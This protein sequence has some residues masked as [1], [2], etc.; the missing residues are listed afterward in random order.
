MFEIT[1]KIKIG[2]NTY[3][4]DRS[5]R[6][7]DLHTD[8]SL[9]IPVNR[10]RLVLAAP[11]AGSI[12][13]ED[14]IAVEVGYNQQNTVVFTGKVRTIKWGIEQVQIE[15]YSQFSA[16]TQARFNRLYEKST[17]GDIV[18]DV[19]QSQL[20]LAVQKV[21]SGIK[22][23]SYAIGDQKTAYDHLH[24][25]AIQS[26]FDFYANSADKVIFAQY[27]SGQAAQFTY[28][29][30]LL[31]YTLDAQ[32]QTIQGVEIYGESPASQGQGEKASSWLTKN[33]VKGTAGNTSGKLQRQFDPT[34]RT[35]AIAGKIAKA[36][37]DRSAKRQ[38]TI[39][40]LGNA[41]AQLGNTVAL[42]D[43]PV[44]GHNG[45]FK[46]IA[47]SHRLNRQQGFCTT[48]HWEEP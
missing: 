42:A 23:P 37:L 43:L 12:A 39:H 6:L 2:S 8:A 28:G 22:F 46:A 29:V 7:L 41:Q 38:G 11:L 20:E 5:S 3:Q 1:Y 35:Q 13:P 27:K 30:N 34:A 17:A 45:S 33:E 21:S 14:A 48:V 4:S 26:G 24:H 9:A 40:G 18:I 32:P 25:L 31:S 47:V 44:R 10:C 36:W 16:L 19:A 15:A